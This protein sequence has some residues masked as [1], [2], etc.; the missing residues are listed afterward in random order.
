MDKNEPNNPNIVE[1]LE[2]KRVILSKQASN[3]LLGKKLQEEGLKH[4]EQMKTFSKSELD[5]K[6]EIENLVS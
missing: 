6:K 2:L 1:H 5:D 4:T 3:T